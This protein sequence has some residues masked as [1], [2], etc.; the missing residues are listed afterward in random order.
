MADNFI[1]PATGDT[2]AADEV[3]NVKYQRTKP[4]HGA[5]GEAPL[6]VSHANPLPIIDQYLSIAAGLC[7]NC[8]SINKFGE[9]PGIDVATVP[10]DVW[11]HGGIYTWSTTAA[12]DT[13]SSSNA[14][15]AVDV[16]VQG[17]DANWD[18]VLQTVTLNGQN[19]VTLATPL[20]RC[21]RAYNVGTVDLVGDMYIYE[22]TPIINGVPVDDTKVRARIT[23]GN[24]QTLMCIYTVPANHTAFFKAGYVALSEKKN[25][26][27]SFTW[28]ARTFGSVFAVKSKIGL[29]ATG[30]SHW[31][32]TYGVPVVL[33]E[34]TDILIRCE[35]TDQSDLAVSGGFDL[36]L[37]ND[38]YTV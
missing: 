19:K 26:N 34:K 27:A 17:L 22:D 12:I 36:I 10:E 38:S 29:M 30:S 23:D 14:V 9:N 6:D 25:A 15:D 2:C 11:D 4:V 37:R 33:P 28:R 20:I 21:Y 1:L 8:T 35:S 7:P 3:A 32:Y 5:P 31:S 16:V 13:V 18:E 24:N